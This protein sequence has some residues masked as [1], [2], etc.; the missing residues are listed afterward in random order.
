MC[1]GI[2]QPL[3][4]TEADFARDINIYLSDLQ[5]SPIRTLKELIAF[6]EE[7]SKEELPP[8]T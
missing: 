7:H 6:N 5:S 4:L 3:K 2:Y 1:Q 8:G